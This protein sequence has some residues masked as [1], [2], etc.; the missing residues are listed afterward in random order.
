M[1]DE[2]KGTMTTEDELLSLGEAAKELG[3]A[4]DNALRWVQRGQLKAERVSG[5]YVVRRADLDEFRE[6]WSA[7]PNVQRGRLSRREGVA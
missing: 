5:R 2:E 3:L 6:W 7:N 1:V 4:Y